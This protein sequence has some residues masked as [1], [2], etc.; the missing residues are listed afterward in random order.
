MLT[1]AEIQGMAERK[2]PAFLQSLVTGESIF[3]MRIRF[4]IPS[5][6]DDFA[7]LQQEVTTLAAGNFGYSIEWEEKN[8]RKHG[9]QKLPSQVRFDSED[10]FV[11]ALGKAGEVQLF[12][13]N[14][15]ASLSRLPQLRDWLVSHVKWVV[16]FGTIWNEMLLVGEY[17][18]ANPRPGLYTRQLPIAAHTKF[19]QENTRVIGSMLDFLL[20]DEAKSDGN[21][22][23]ERFGLKPLAPLVRFRMLD[24][25]LLKTLALSHSEMGLPLEVFSR[26][27]IHG[28]HVI[29]TENLMNFECLPEA[30]NTL[31]IW[32]QGNA[33]EL[34]HK[35]PW[36]ADCDVYYWG[37]IDEHG[38]QILSRLRSKF[39]SIRS[40][41]MEVD[42]FEKYRHLTGAGEKAGKPP[43]NLTTEEQ[44][45][46]DI[47][48]REKLR[49]EQEKIPQPVLG[50]FITFKH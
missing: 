12:R 37:D 8:T 4:G 25:M 20:P 33:A 36:L 14:I 3:P 18:L 34:L 9:V 28:L 15:S 17:F 22:F 19:V 42:T 26:L 38:F 50:D 2:Y 48:A 31:A 43:S 10:Q 24:Q 29:I 6:T 39:P 23:E 46:Y 41:M 27:P 7:K 13:A 49:L 21:S 16:E 32:G 11:K 1:P 47:V 5:T 30:A 45:A 40:V 44:K 35:V